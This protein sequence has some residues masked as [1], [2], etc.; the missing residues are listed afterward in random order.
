M[1]YAMKLRW[2]I[3]GV[4]KINDRLLPAF[5]V[6]NNAELRAIASRSAGRVQAASA[7]AGIPVSYGNYEALLDDPSIDAVYIPLPNHLHGEYTRKAA[8]RGKHVLVEKP[9]APTADEAGEVVDYCRRK[10]VRLMDGFMWPHHPRTAQLREALR[11]GII[12]DV[13]HVNGAFTFP[14]EPDPKNI[15]LNAEMGGGSLLDVGCYP[16]YGIRWVFAAEPLSVQATASLE[17]GVD[18]RMAGILKFANDR[19]GSFDC[20]FTLPLRTAMEIVGTEGV[21]RVPHMWVPL[22]GQSY[23]EI[24]RG[25][26]TQTV[27]VE[28]QNQIVNMLQH[29]GEAVLNRREASPSPDEAVKTLKVLDALA[30]AARDGREVKIT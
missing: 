12:G 25:G 19:T 9:L 29:F 16:V 14:L 10:N 18:M 26:K 1:D 5:A 20:G 2:G 21:I 17:R 22:P 24:E 13:V 15:R 3:L 7:A 4:A 8:D 6:A 11:G 30:H 28:G 23:F 27:S